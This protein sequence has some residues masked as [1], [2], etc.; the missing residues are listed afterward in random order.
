MIKSILAVSLAV[1]ATGCAN[2]LTPQQRAAFAAALSDISAQQYDQAR[3]YQDQAFQL[4]QTMNQPRPVIIQQVP[5]QPQW[6][7]PS[8]K[9]SGPMCE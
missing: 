1:L 8:G 3:R 5:V 4:R 2:K 9:K 7:C 6:V